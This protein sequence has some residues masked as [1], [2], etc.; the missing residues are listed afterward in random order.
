[1]RWQMEH[2]FGPLAGPPIALGKD[3]VFASTRGSLWLVDEKG[4]IKAQHEI[5][6]PLGSGPSA[7]RDRL[8]VSGWDG[9]IYL[10]DIP[11]H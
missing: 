1:M 10:T 4:Q 2:P 9:T 5:G 8:L 11:G 7:F 3:L 6:E